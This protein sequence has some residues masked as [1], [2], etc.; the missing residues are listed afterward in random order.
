MNRRLLALA[1][2]FVLL[3]SAVT[4]GMAQVRPPGPDVAPASRARLAREPGR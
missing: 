2:A 4:P 1:A 3:V